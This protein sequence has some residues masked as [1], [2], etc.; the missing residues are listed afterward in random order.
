MKPMTTTPNTSAPAESRLRLGHLMVLVALCAVFCWLAAKGGYYI[1]VLAGILFLAAS[2]VGTSVALIRRRSSLQGAFLTWL[3]IA[4]ERGMPLPEAVES[5]AEQCGGRYRRLLLAAADRLRHG[6]PVTHA[7]SLRGVLPSEAR[8]LV[9]AGCAT[10]DLAG[11]LREAAAVGAERQSLWF[12]LASRLSYLL[13]A[14][15]VIQTIAGFVL[16][17]ITPKFEAIFRDFGVSLPTSTLTVIRI[18]H[19]ISGQWSWA[20][21]L[22]A[23]LEYIAAVCLPFA[24]AGGAFGR[25]PLADR[26]LLRRHTALILRALAR[27]VERDRPLWE[28]VGALAKIVPAG[29]IRRWLRRV[30]DDLDHGADW[31]RSLHSRGLI[32]TVDAAL[33]E[34]AQRAGNLPWALRETAEGGERRLSYRIQAWIGML[35]PVAVIALGCLVF[36]LAVAYFQPLVTLIEALTEWT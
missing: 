15:L 16:Y 36:L 31:C 3:A 28:A 23:G 34:S 9:W 17:Y 10:G 20:A 21:A 12:P 1:I 7:L 8:V 5:F 18:G 6:A 25:L 26:F 14:L 19:A 35:F 22:V 30:A 29:G 27:F 33:L 13:Y 2:G 32:R 24:V 4:V 11:A